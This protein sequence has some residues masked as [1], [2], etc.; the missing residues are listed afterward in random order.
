MKASHTKS[1]RSSRQKI[2]NKINA[3][4]VKGE[5][6]ARCSGPGDESV[7]VLL[8]PHARTHVQLP[9]SRTTWQKSPGR[10]A[11]TKL[12]ALCAR[13]KKTTGRS[14]ENKRTRIVC[15]SDCSLPNRSYFSRDYCLNGKETTMTSPIKDI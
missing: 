7:Q 9:I 13:R 12:C 3:H 4:H 2:L 11:C 1:S 10:A 6:F 5:A 15:V 14:S 8:S